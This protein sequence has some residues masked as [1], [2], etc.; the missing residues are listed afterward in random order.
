LAEIFVRPYQASDR[1]DVF[2]I[3]ADTAFFGKPVEAFLEDRQLFCDV[4]YRYYTDLESKH[5]W[6]VCAS[7]QV[8]GF[9][10]GCTN[11]ASREI[12][13]A[14]RI[15][16]GVIWGLLKRR[17]QIGT[18][19]T[20]YVLGLIRANLHQEIAHADWKK[21][22]AH[23]HIN[24]KAD[25]QGKGLGHRL[26]KAFLEQL[27]TSGVAGVHLLTT[28]INSRACRLYEMLGFTLLDARPTRL[29]EAYT[30]QVIENRC[31]GL[32]LA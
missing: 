15:L 32:K 26:M 5:G 21:Y 10:M 16:P 6:V 9:L 11:T 4:F 2:R 7:D 13:W 29:W 8:V 17:Y 27:R 25:W 1:E 22:P 18:L 30:V 24:V 23:L 3:A 19:T 14:R 28:N 12:R 31:Y 20:Q